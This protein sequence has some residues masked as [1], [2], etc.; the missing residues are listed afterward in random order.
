MNSSAYIAHMHLKFGMCILEL[1]MEG[2]LSQNLDLAPGIYFIKCGI[3]CIKNIQKV[4]S[5][6]T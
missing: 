6:L 1:Q 3:W 5:F 2:A 4:T